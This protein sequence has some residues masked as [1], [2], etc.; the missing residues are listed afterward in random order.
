M[1]KTER[2]ED[3]G[4]LSILGLFPVD[5]NKKRVIFSLLSV[6]TSMGTHEEWSGLTSFS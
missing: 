2:P 5:P 4:V 6:L 1:T 3:F